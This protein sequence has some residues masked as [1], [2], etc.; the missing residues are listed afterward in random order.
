MT[1]SSGSPVAST[2]D[3]LS[4]IM[5]TLETMA[6]VMQQQQPV[7]QGSNDGI[8]TSNRTGL[9]I[10][11]FKKLSPPSFSGESDPMVAERWMMQIEKIFDAL[12]YSDERKVFLATF[13]LEGE[14][15][16]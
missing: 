12:S 8:E 15:E 3:Q 11:Q 14:A 9:G 4:G 16:H 6:Q 5:R 10:G 1:R 7:Q 13:M 2:V